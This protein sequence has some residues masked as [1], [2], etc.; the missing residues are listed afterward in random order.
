M[1]IKATHLVIAFLLAFA[2]GFVGNH[3]FFNGELPV[4]F[5]ILF[6]SAMF[7]V[8]ASYN[9]TAAK[10]RNILVALVFVVGIIWFVIWIQGI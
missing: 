1:K 6:A 10:M 2:L 9:K 5:P 3:L 8:L 7:F 4:E